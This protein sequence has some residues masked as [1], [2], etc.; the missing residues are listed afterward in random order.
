[1]LLHFLVSRYLRLK[2]L[3]DSMYGCISL[4]TL[5]PKYK[6][7]NLKKFI[8]ERTFSVQVPEQKQMSK[9]LGYG[10]LPLFC[11]KQ[12]LKTYKENPVMI[13]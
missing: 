4:P 8:R 12:W 6:Y 11:L 9:A 7:N 2:L 10:D 5:I 3:Q 1:M 13:S